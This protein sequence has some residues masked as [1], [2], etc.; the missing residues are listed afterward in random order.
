MVFALTFPF[1]WFSL[2]VLQVFGAVYL[3]KVFF[4]SFHFIHSKI[5]SV[6]FFK[7]FSEALKFLTIFSVYLL[8]EDT[9]VYKL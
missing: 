1:T 4:I 2:L 3:I 8:T 5:L 7:S 6:S 9:M